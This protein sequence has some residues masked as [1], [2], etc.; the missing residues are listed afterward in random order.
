M[1][2]NH[3]KPGTVELIFGI[4]FLLWHHGKRRKGNPWKLV[5]QLMTFSVRKGNRDFVSNKVEGKDRHPTLSSDL[6][7][8]AVAHRY[9]YFIKIKNKNK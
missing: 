2:T 8:C 7:M 3:V 1:P 9:L 4:G 5:G 6:H